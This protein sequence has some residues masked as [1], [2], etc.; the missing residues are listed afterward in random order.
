M[1]KTRASQKAEGERR[2][3][4][5]GIGP[6]TPIGIGLEAFWQGLLAQESAIRRLRRFDPS[7]GRAR[8]SAELADFRPEAYFPPHRLKRLDRC[9]QL[10]MVSAKLAIADAGLATGELGESEAHRAGVIFGTALGGISDAELEHAKFLVSGSRAVH[11]S[12]ALQIFG[13]AAHSNIAIEYGFG[14]VSTTNSNSCASGNV[15]LGDAFR[16]IRGGQLDLAIA[17]A[18]ESPIA[19]LTFSA[20]DNIATMSRWEGVPECRACRPFDRA[21]DGF[22]MGEGACSFVMEELEHAR[23][24]GA[25]ILAE[26]RGFSHNNEAYHMTTPRPG[27]EPVRRAMRMALEDA[28]IDP[29]SIDHINAH[30]SSTQL[31][32]ANEAHAIR[33]LFGEHARALTV[34][35]TKAY[36][37]HPLGAASA[38]EAA[39]C[40]LAIQR[41]W[42]PP[43]L[44]YE[45]SEPALAE[46]GLDFVPNEGRETK[47]R[48]CLNNA[49]GF[50][51][52][53]TCLVLAAPTP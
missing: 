51:G 18:A 53:N 2:V 21:R 38:I 4:I 22:V 34:V 26:V 52:I 8:H 19:P 13:G 37:G 31:N 6:V 20:F 16:L 43:T 32:D 47:V 17:G 10:A 15:A 23:R 29:G 25:D 3:V 24:R 39:C 33:D 28:R 46:L 12:L 35:G 48:A 5:T 14:G 7:P 30:A 1:M 11:R 9:A 45:A 27:G 50:G 44:H 49:F 41:G 40:V 42:T 36:T